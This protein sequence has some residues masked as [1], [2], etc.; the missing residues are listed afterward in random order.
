MTPEEMQYE[1]DAF[2]LLVVG[3]SLEVKCNDALY[4]GWIA[5]YYGR[6]DYSKRGNNRNIGAIAETPGEA[7]RRAHQAL[8]E[9]IESKRI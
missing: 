9:Y 2:S 6:L 7:I 8:T 4:G 1:L 3:W 5:N